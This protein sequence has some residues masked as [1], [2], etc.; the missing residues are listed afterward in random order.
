[1][2]DRNVEFTGLLSVLS[3]PPLGIFDFFLALDLAPK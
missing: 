2:N 1:M 3:V